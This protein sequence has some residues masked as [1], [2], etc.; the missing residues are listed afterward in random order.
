MV[1]YYSEFGYSY[2]LD[3]QSKGRGKMK[4]RHW[5]VPKEGQIKH[6]LLLG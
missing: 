5:K 3:G 6:Q 1:V 4:L 2:R